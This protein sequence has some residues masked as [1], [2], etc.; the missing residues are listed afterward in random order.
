VEALL[1]HIY[2][3]RDCTYSVKDLT[4]ES[5]RKDRDRLAAAAAAAL[6]RA[7]VDVDCGEIEMILEQVIE[8]DGTIIRPKE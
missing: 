7:Q 3:N 2:N 8:L 6:E 5:L 1:R 4:I